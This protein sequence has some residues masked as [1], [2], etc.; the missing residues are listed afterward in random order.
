MNF[1]LHVV[2]MQYMNFAI[3]CCCHAIVVTCFD[4]EKLFPDGRLDYLREN[5]TRERQYD[6]E[7]SVP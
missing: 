2:A 5:R 4:P 7:F 3:A 6:C 1:L